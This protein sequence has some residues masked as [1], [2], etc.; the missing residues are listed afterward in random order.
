MPVLKDHSVSLDTLRLALIGGLLL[1]LSACAA[2]DFSPDSTASNNT[3]DIA[4]GVGFSLL[5]PVVGQVSESVLQSVKAAVGNET[6]D[7]LVQIEST[8]QYLVMVVLT[9]TGNRLAT[10]KLENGTVSSEQLPVLPDAFQAGQLLAAY[11]LSL[12]PLDN[13]NK[14]LQGQGVSISERPIPSVKRILA[15][16]GVPVIAIE[17]GSNE[18]GQSQILYRHLQWQYQIAITTLERQPL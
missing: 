11:Q 10:V 6:H 1:V 13:L 8:E 18:Q 12:W 2:F 17:F 5:P 15:V 4:D 9:P 14:A 3:L 7:L 16:A